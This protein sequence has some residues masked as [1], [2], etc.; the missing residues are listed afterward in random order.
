M[1]SAEDD[2]LGF[3]DRQTVT[4]DGTPIAP[5]ID[6]VW[7]GSQVVHVDH[8]GRVFEV[9]TEA[10]PYWD[11]PIVHSYVF[12]VRPGY[13]K[14][15]GVHDHKADRYVCI[16]GEMLAVMYDGR[17]DSPTRGLV[18]EVTMSAA[19]VQLLRIPPGVWHA[20][21]NVGTRECVLMNHPTE[22]YDYEQPDRRTLP[23]NSPEIPVDLRAYLPMQRGDA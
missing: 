21:I 15:W 19:G 2:P 18:Q 16:T 5:C 13:V 1:S 14:G 6:G 20:D 10:N 9:F 12:T 7:L 3:P 11:T 8:R 22:P 4:P 17:A 23:W